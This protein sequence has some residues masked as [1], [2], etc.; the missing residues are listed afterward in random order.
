MIQNKSWGSFLRVEVVDGAL[1]VR[2][3]GLVTQLDVHL[4]PPN[5]IGECPPPYRLVDDALVSRT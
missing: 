1:A 2:E 4:P 5:F 3:E